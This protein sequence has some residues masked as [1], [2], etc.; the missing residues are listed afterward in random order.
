MNKECNENVL[1]QLYV[2]K[3]VDPKELVQYALKLGISCQKLNNFILSEQYKNNIIMNN[4]FNKIIT[5]NL[6]SSFDIEHFYDVISSISELE[7]LC[8]SIDY[9]H[10]NLKKNPMNFVDGLEKLKNESFDE[11]ELYYDDITSK[12]NIYD[13]KMNN[14]IIELA[15]KAGISTKKLVAMLNSNLEKVSNDIGGLIKSQMINKDYSSELLPL[16]Q[17]TKYL[18]YKISSLEYNYPKYCENKFQL[19]NAIL[20]CDVSD[21]LKYD[22]IKNEDEILSSFVLAKRKSQK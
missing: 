15:H 13:E 3:T 21:L 9:E 18:A 8:A 5:Y 10:P 19:I 4:L 2:T 11:F 12:V 14:I 17:N 7:Y 20:N 1:E 6:Y 16:L 22:S